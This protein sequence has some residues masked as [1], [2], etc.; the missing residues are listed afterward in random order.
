[1]VRLL[2]TE[3]WMLTI[4]G[5]AIA[6]CPAV[7]ST[8]LAQLVIRYPPLLFCFLLVATTPPPVLGYFHPNSTHIRPSVHQHVSLEIRDLNSFHQLA[9]QRLVVA[10]YRLHRIVDILTALVV[11]DR[12]QPKDRVI[13][14]FWQQFLKVFSSS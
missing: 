1:M 13:L 11:M 12:A 5:W 9:I 10:V 8:Y 2:S 6:H 3:L 7:S 14:V 4:L